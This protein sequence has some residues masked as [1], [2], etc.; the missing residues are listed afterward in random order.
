MHTGLV[1]ME[2]TVQG[3]VFVRYKY[4]NSNSWTIIYYLYSRF[5]PQNKCKIKEIQSVLTP[6]IIHITI[7]IIQIYITFDHYHCV[8]SYLSLKSSLSSFVIEIISIIINDRFLIFITITTSH[9]IKLFYVAIIFI[10][11]FITIIWLNNFINFLY[12][13]FL[14][15]ILNVIFIF[16]F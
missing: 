9:L 3:L 14:I 4:I 1:G 15:F 7:I 8:L 2:C 16:I 13:Y 5:K 10:I 6:S 12:F 11:N